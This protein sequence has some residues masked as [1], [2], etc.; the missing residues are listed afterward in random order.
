MSAS[1]RLWLLPDAQSRAWIEATS[2]AKYVPSPFNGFDLLNHMAKLW[3]P[4]VVKEEAG[5][6]METLLKEYKENHEE[7]F[8]LPRRREIPY[9]VREASHVWPWLRALP[10]PA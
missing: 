5:D 1:K 8:H 2:Q 3:L 4:P 10:L 6:A 7:A 9:H